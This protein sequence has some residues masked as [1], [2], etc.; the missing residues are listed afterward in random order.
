MPSPTR[1]TGGPRGP[2]GKPTGPLGPRGPRQAL[3]LYRQ[4]HGATLMVLHG[5]LTP[6]KREINGI[7]CIEL[8]F[9]T[10]T[11]T[12]PLLLRHRTE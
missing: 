8:L 10:Q 12:C 9:A 7:R 1:D 5:Q 6:L 11:V 2:R 3:T 4:L